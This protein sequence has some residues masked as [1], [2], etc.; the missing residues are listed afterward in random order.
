MVTGSETLTYNVRRRRRYEKI[1]WIWSGD[2]G[3]G[4]W[5]PWPLGCWAG[6]SGQGG[7]NIAK[8]RETERICH[9][10]IKPCQEE[11]H[12]QG[13]R[14]CQGSKSLWK[15]WQWGA[16]FYL[17]LAHGS[18]GP[19]HGDVILVHDVEMRSRGLVFV[20]SA[21]YSVRSMRSG[22]ESIYLYDY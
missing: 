17:S 14:I 22:L 3:F 9:V 6:L 12:C 15:R 20:S 8:L 16:M 7:K 21:F 18:I 2:P 11:E 4:S 10:R 5:L 1:W 13:G 19:V